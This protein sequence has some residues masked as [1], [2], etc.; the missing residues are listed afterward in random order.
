MAKRN[1]A[2]PRRPSPQHFR[3]RSFAAVVPTVAFALALLAAGCASPGE[4]TA[5]KPLVPERVT[6]F[7]AAQT[8]NH[9]L[10]TFTVPESST[11]GRVLDHPP[12]IEIYRDFE[13]APASGKLHPAVLKHPTLLVTI[14]AELVPHYLAGDEFRYDNALHSSDFTGHPD[15]IAVYSV[16]TRVS[17]KKLSEPSNIAA[18]RVYPA[19]DPINDLA[20]K[21]TP[22]VVVLSWTPPQRTPIGPVSA[23]VGYRIY[24]SEAQSGTPTSGTPGT[25]AAAAPSNPES[26]SAPPGLPPSPPPLQSP[27]VKIGESTSPSFTDAQAKFDKTY[28]YS[29]R[30]V[31]NDSG[32]AVESSDSNFLVITPR[33]TFPPAAPKG[34]VVVYVPAAAGVPAHVDL[35]WAVSSE[36][37]LAGYRVY[38]SNRD[39]ALGTRANRQLLLT[40]AFRDMNVVSGRRYYYSVT[41]VD[42]SGNESAPSAVVSVNVPAGPARP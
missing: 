2:E 37:D 20:G 10:L 8:G 14:P 29:V 38:R 12:T 35:S 15:S 33:D 18:L 36:P 16:R 32:A 9:V 3:G 23:L 4:P 1:S 34:L 5:R 28:V 21:V 6:N 11:S 27:L 31:V 22:T 26:T 30:S 24:R 17:G 7:A 39:D 42:R 41:A 13:P 25:D 19:P 40:P